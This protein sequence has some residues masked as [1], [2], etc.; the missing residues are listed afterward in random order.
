MIK[1]RYKPKRSIRTGR[2]C[3]HKA[4]CFL[5]AFIMIAASFPLDTFTVFAGNESPQN[6]DAE[7]LQNG[8][9]RSEEDGLEPAEK[10]E[11][12]EKPD[13]AGT[14]NY[15]NSISGSLWLD[16]SEDAE[17]GVFSGDGIRQ[18]GE[19]PLADYEVSLY[20][21][22]NKADAVET[23]ATDGDGTYRFENREPGSYVVG[24]SATTIHG[25]EYLLPIAGIT[26]DNR[27]ADSN[28]DYTTV[29]SESIV[30][31]ADTQVA[32]IDAGMRTLP[33]VMPFGAIEYADDEASL[34][35]AVGKVDD[36]GRVQ[37]R[38]S[39]PV[40]TPITIPT[41]KSITLMSAPGGLHTITETARGKGTVHFEVE[42]SLTLKDIV[43]SA[44]SYPSLNAS[45]VIGGV[46]VGAGGTLTMESGT[47]ITNCYAG[48]K[49]GA[50]YVASNGVFNMKGGEISANKATKD[51]GGIFVDA[52]AEFIMDAGEISGNT[53]IQASGAGVCVN[54]NGKFTMNGG[55]IFENEAP[56]GG[57]AVCTTGNGSSFIME[58][59]EIFD[60]TT[61]SF[62]GG[63]CVYY[64][65]TFTMKDGKKGG[66]IYNN[67]IKADNGGGVYVDAM[68]TFIMED[69]EISGNKA[70]S[71]GGGVYVSAKDAKDSNGTFIMTGGEISGN[72]A[73][74]GAGVYVY[75]RTNAIG[76]FTMDGGQISGNKASGNG[77]GVYLG[78]QGSIY[79]FFDMTGGEI[80]GNT[81]G[82]DGGGIYTTNY[83]YDKNPVTSVTAYYNNVRIAN[84]ATVENNEAGYGT[85]A[86][87]GNYEDFTNRTSNPFDGLLLDND[88]I[89]Y[90]NPHLRAVF[91][92]NNDKD[93]AEPDYS[94]QTGSSAS[95]S[96]TMP[97]LAEAGFTAPDGKVFLG[98][99]ESKGGAAADVNLPGKQVVISANKT[100]YASW[101]T[102]RYL[103]YRDN[104]GAFI[105]GRNILKAAVAICD[106]YATSGSYTIVATQDDTNMGTGVEIPG[107]KRITLT[108]DDTIRTIKQVETD[109]KARH[110]AV[111]G[112]SLT[113]KNVILAGKGTRGTSVQKNGGVEIEEGGSFTM[114]EGAKITDCYINQGGSAVRI[115][116]GT[117]TMNGGEISNGYARCNADNGGAVDV[118]VRS[119]FVMNGGKIIGNE[120]RYDGGAVYV[121]ANNVGGAGTFTMN[122]GEITGNKAGRDGGAIYARKMKLGGQEN[123]AAIIL[124]DGKILNNT[125]AKNGGAIF[126]KDYDGVVGGGKYVDPMKPATDYYR[127]IKISD[128]VVFS[129]NTAVKTHMPPS[130]YT[131]FTNRSVDPFDGMLLDN[132]NINY[133]NPARTVAYHA[134][135]GGIGQQKYFQKLAGTSTTIP[136]AGVGTGTGEADFTAPEGKVFEKWTENADG[137]GNSYAPGDIVT[138]T[139]QIKTKSLYAQWREAVKVDLTLSKMVE[140]DY[141]DKNKVFDFKITL[142]NN[143][144]APLTGTFAYTGGIVSGSGAAAPS[145][146]TLNLDSTGSATLQLKHG[147]TIT[148]KNIPETSKVRI[149]EDGTIAAGYSTTYKIDNG[150]S[151]SGMD[152]GTVTIPGTNC[153]IDFVN[154][155]GS[156]VSAGVSG[157]RMQNAISLSGTVLCLTGACYVLSRFVKRR[158]HG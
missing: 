21:A 63:V 98:W 89:N 88:N 87:P 56:N 140:G 64:G 120:A 77:G 70:K 111:K 7:L 67:K 115:A 144:G 154:S 92:A 24:V 108:S 150:S 30:M 94:I 85:Q 146:D 112:G 62:G 5:L 52:Y 148:V 118:Q 55:K 102:S 14:T 81:A 48:E 99:A 38:K 76:T 19:Q 23:V 137:S 42:G 60:N 2:D 91:K 107:T 11:E 80:S 37:L 153:R 105:A 93:P 143:Q 101:G 34:R 26:D 33:D 151:K 43:L 74:N 100:F 51:G 66:K 126:V 152:T 133:E 147:Q 127:K 3:W 122:D 78:N 128:Q 41:G 45:Q 8:G 10:K 90:R 15:P 44:N 54:P 97:T 1:P 114:E 17:N 65:S 28:D 53:S 136:A 31:E 130:N 39:F 46:K 29:Y 134:N 113:I 131:D 68:S 123:L 125:A 132:D 12:P 20:K 4:V 145:D 157:G 25:T 83:Q 75:A 61:Y 117:F 22:D 96:I 13:E 59:G 47:K 156:V 141:G 149:E 6:A 18:S 73:V 16:T 135:N 116:S 57:G 119:T 27:F 110:F 139:A 106:N 158:R 86:P 49:G 82:T 104:D 32:D 36:G 9:E 155:R 95:T 109:D 50:V 129:G 71:S 121:D 124:K 58:G 69:G 84:S 103:V 79:A 35:T 40:T 72:E 138:V 142:Q